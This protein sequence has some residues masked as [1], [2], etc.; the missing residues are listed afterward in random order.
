MA[1]RQPSQSESA[2]RPMRRWI[3][4]LFVFTV[5]AGVSLYALHLTEGF[6]MRDPRFV[7]AGPQ[8]P[9]EESRNLQIEG[10]THASRA[11]V[12]SAFGPDFGKSVYLVPLAERRRNLLAVNWVRDATVLRV[13]PNEVLVRITERSPVAFVQ[14]PQSE[15][16]LI[17]ADG[18]L[19]PIDNPAE[20]RLPVLTGIRTVHGESERRLR[21]RKMQR[22][23]EEVGPR[24]EM[25]SEINAADPENLKLTIT[26]A[27]RA[28]VLLIGNRRFRQRLD[29]FQKHYNEIRMRAPDATVFDLRLEDRI[30]VVQTSGNAKTGDSHHFS[31]TRPFIGNR[32]SVPGEK[33]LTV[34]GF[35]Q[36]GGAGGD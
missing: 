7:F 35:G 9:G 36:A 31:R 14:P 5:F 22:L 4:G 19:L 6:L 1:R 15:T 12:A 24:S 30:T 10:V 18:V 13:W 3:A 2:S 23:L 20:F 28:L 27:G 34:P 25:I 8:E 16:A 17:D 33:W 32:A 29:N 26:V 11:H 21:V